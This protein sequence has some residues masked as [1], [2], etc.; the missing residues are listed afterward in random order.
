MSKT[1]LPK[2]T[3]VILAAQA[4]VAAA[5]IVLLILDEYL[6]WAYMVSLLLLLGTIQ[7][8]RLRRARHQLDREYI[9]ILQA[10]VKHR[11]R[12]LTPHEP[13]HTIDD[14][15]KGLREDIERH[16]NEV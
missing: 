2:Y 10:V 14:D 15:L 7:L 3:F 4:V 9:Q 8:Y 13:Q 6:L 12:E 16:K 5:C 1:T 11:N